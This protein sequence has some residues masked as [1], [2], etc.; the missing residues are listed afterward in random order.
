MARPKYIEPQS[1]IPESIQKEF[2]VGKY[3]DADEE[4]GKKKRESENKQLRKV[5]KG[6]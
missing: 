4:K 1:Y 6:K 2:G 3:Y 5:I